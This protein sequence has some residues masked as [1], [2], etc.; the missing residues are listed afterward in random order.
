MSLLPDPERFRRL[1][2]GRSGG[3]LCTAA[4][5]GLS[6]IAAPYGLAMAVRNGGYDRG[7][8][9]AHAAGAPVVSVGNL[10]LGGTGKTPLVA[11]V[12]ARL[13]EQGR[14]P[15]IVSRGYGAAA[16]MLSDEAAELGITLPGVPHLADRDRVK[17]ARSAVAHGA[18]V[19]VLDDGFQH[20]RLRRDFDLVA[21][22][23]TDPF[24]TGRLFPRGLL[25]EPW[26]GVRRADAAVLT[27]S[28]AIDRAARDAIRNAV[29][30]ARGDRPL[31]WAEA[32]HRPVALRGWSGTT[33]PLETLHGRRVLAFAAIGNPAAF[34]AT[35]R[36]S[37]AEITDFLCFPDHHAYAASDLRRLSDAARASHVDMAVTTLKDLVK[38][39]QDA[40]GEAALVAVQIEIQM[41]LGGEDLLTAIVESLPARAPSTQNPDLPSGR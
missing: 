21:V 26:H 30:T 18:D 31:V 32:V 2:D 12:G 36:D 5:A 17:A 35:L 1:I 19:I 9:R 40:I 41:T 24:G 10:T 11:W 37:G 13:R 20:R 39:R 22:D 25:R 16:G 33:R 3:I 4:R 29:A 27:R 28:N 34:A 7:F 6:L 23:A 8:F 14:R 15:S 38:I